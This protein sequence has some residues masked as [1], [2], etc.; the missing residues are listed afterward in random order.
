MTWHALTRPPGCE[1][2]SQIVPV[3]AAGVLLNL[4]RARLTSG[5]RCLPPPKVENACCIHVCLRSPKL[6]RAFKFV[7]EAL[8]VEM[9]GKSKA[10]PREVV[11]DCNAGIPHEWSSAKQ[12]L[13]LIK[14]RVYDDR[15]GLPFDFGGEGASDVWIRHSIC[16]KLKSISHA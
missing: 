13:V 7:Y 16:C 10:Q 3:L 9:I 15:F 6:R 12:A 4:M 14:G 11:Y 5:L 1:Q 2:D 8:W